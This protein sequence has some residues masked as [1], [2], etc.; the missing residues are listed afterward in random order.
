MKFILLAA[1]VP[2]ALC[3]RGGY[4]GA[5]VV[6]KVCEDAKEQQ[7][8]CFE[9]ELTNAGVTFKMEDVRDCLKQCPK[10]EWGKGKGEVDE[11]QKAKWEAKKAE[12]EEM[13]QSF[14]DYHECLKAE[15][16]DEM[17]QCVK[18][19]VDFEFVENPQRRHRGGHG[20]FKP[21]HHGGR[22]HGGKGGKGRH[23][24]GGRGHHGGKGGK[25]RHGR[26]G[27][28]HGLFE[29][30][31][32]SEDVN[33]CVQGVVGDWYG[34]QA[35]LKQAMCD[36]DSKCTPEPNEQC[37][38]QFEQLREVGKECY[39]DSKDDLEAAQ[40]TCK[41]KLPEEI[42]EKFEAH[43]GKGKGSWGSESDEED[44]GEDSMSGEGKGWG[45]RFGGKRHSKWC[46]ADMS[47]EDDEDAEE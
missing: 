40:E 22:H 4:H 37:H 14:E 6:P 46:D 13:K 29:L 17:E 33:A 21:G 43:K 9:N 31:E 41:A 11:E 3:G 35:E 19:K 25:G 39:E 23:G 28:H 15:L 16:G 47:V 38:E 45:K 36:A 34:K 20:H 42:R 24:K 44:S 26:H 1:I 8:Q 18:D 27:H 32:C 30:A 2:L 10:P 7:K 12:W 5:M